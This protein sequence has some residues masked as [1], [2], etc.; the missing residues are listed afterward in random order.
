MITIVDRIIKGDEYELLELSSE[1]EDY[2]ENIGDFLDLL[3]TWFRDLLIVKK[4]NDD[5]YLIN[6]DK[7]KTLLKQSQVLS[8]NKISVMIDNIINAKNLLRQNSNIRLVIEMMILQTK[9]N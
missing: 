7:Y 6:R 3:M 9:E 5:L 2:K 4:I 8:Y 1:F